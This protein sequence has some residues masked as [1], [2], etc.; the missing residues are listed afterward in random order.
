MLGELV[1]NYGTNTLSAVFKAKNLRSLR[2]LER[3]GFKR[4]APGKSL[5]VEPD[6]LLMQYIMVRQEA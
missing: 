5:Q 3:L 4:A 2:L 1:E 6:E